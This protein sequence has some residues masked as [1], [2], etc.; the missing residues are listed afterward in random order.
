MDLRGRKRVPVTTVLTVAG[1]EVD[2]I[3]KSIKRINLSVRPPHGRVRVSA[4]FQVPEGRI[5][6]VVLGRLDW[7]RTHQAHI[8]A[9]PVQEPKAF[10][11]GD[12]VMVWGAEQPL[13]VRVGSRTLARWTGEQVILTC[14]ETATRDQRRAAI[15]RMYRRCLE[16]ELP[17]LLALWE[18]VIGHRVSLVAYRRMKTRWGT[19]QPRTGVI[20]LNTELAKYHP[21]CLE[22]VVVHELVHFLESAHNQ[23]FKG[24]MDQFLPDWRVRKEL[25]NTSGL[26]EGDPP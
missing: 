24:F 22:Y 5:R 3:Y 19:C 4:P 14:P 2:V 16:G 7:I 17:G 8:A 12:R 6:E 13:V 15:D 11:N 23:R 10:V 9:Q 26:K 18:P 1:Q 21:A 20:R 25:L